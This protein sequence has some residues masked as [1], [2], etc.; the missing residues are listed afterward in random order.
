MCTDICVTNKLQP[1]LFTANYTHTN[2]CIAELMQTVLLSKKNKLFIKWVK[3][4]RPWM[5]VY[6][7]DYNKCE[8]LNLLRLIR[9]FFE[10]R[11]I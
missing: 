8:E 6:W 4:K 2:E 1:V 7:F 5:K 9:I 10:R 3:R 11:K